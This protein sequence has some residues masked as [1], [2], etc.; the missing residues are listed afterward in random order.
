MSP[1][2]PF[3]RVQANKRIDEIL[4]SSGFVLRNYLSVAKTLRLNN[5]PAFADD[6]VSFSKLQN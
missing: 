4:E 6:S 1:K 5:V 2:S 3:D